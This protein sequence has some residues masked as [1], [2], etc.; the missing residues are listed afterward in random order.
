VSGYERGEFSAVGR[1]GNELSSG[2]DSQIVWSAV[3]RGICAGTAPQLKLI[4]I[5]PR[6]RTGLN[7]LRKLNFNI[8]YSFYKGQYEIFNKKSLLEMKPSLASYIKLF[9]KSVGE[10]SFNI[11][12]A[13]KVYKVESEWLNGYLRFYREF[14]K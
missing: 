5:I 10:C 2:E 8:A 1:K 12:D 9:F 14:P 7:Y 4:H 6:K 11:F 13:A 3:K